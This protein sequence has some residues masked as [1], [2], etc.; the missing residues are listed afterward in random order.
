[1]KNIAISI[2]SLTILFSCQSENKIATEGKKVEVQNSVSLTAQQIA[3]MDLQIGKL[4]K[5]S[6]SAILRVNGTIDVPPQNLVSIS[7]PMGGFLKH[8]K[9]L[10]GMHVSKGEVIAVIEDQQYIQ[11]QQDYLTTATKLKYLEADFERQKSLNQSK[12]TRYF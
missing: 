10:P 2:L 9:L 6:I 7:V 8:T 4:E 3:N 11:M 5:R 12:T 1:M